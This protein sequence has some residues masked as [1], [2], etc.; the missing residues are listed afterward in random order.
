MRKCTQIFDY[1][2]NFRKLTRPYFGFTNVN[3]QSVDLFVTYVTLSKYE[4]QRLERHLNELDKDAFMIKNEGISIDGNF[5][6]YLT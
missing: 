2:E 5:K 4:L 3:S 6:K 1:S